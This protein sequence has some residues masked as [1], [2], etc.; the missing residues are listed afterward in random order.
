LSYR[1]TSSAAP[2]LLLAGALLAFGAPVRAKVGTA[3]GDT[4][5]DFTLKD[6]SGAT[7]TLAQYKGSV[8][9]LYFAMWCSTCRANAFELQREIHLPLKEKKV[10]VF[11]VDYLSNPNVDLLSVARDLGLEY[12]VLL[13]D[14]TLADLYG[15][16]M[17]TTLVIDQS[18]IIRCRD[19]YDLEKVKALVWTLAGAKAAPKATPTRL[20]RTAKA[21]TCPLPNR[22]RIQETQAL[23]GTSP[24]EF[25]G[26]AVPHRPVDMNRDGI[27]DVVVASPSAAG[28][29][30]GVFIR[31]GKE[32]GYPDAPDITL[33]GDAA[34]EKL[35][36]SLLVRDMNGDGAPDLIA[37]SSMTQESSG[38]VS[39]FL[40]SEK[41]LPSKPAWTA[42]GSEKG[43]WFGGALAAGDLDGDGHPDLAVAASTDHHRGSVSIYY[44][45]STGPGEKPGTV[46]RGE[47]END[48]FGSSLAVGDLNA[49]GIDDLVIGAT[50]VN[51]PGTDRG[52]IYVFFGKKGGMGAAPSAAGADLMILG[53]HDLDEFGGSVLCAGDLDADGH[54]DLAA[55][56][57][58]SS[59][60]ARR[61]GAVYLFYGPFAR[62][63]AKSEAMAA[64]DAGTILA[65]GEAE[66]LYGVSLSALGDVNQDGLDDLGVGAMNAVQSP[67]RAGAAFIY[68][69][70]KDRKSLKHETLFGS[71]E[72]GRFGRDI[73]PM[74]GSR[75]L[76]TETGNSERAAKAGAVHL[77]AHPSAPSPAPSRSTSQEETDCQ[78]CGMTLSRYR[79][80]RYEVTTKDGSKLVT[81]GVQCGLILQL[82]LGERFASAQ[83]T[84]FITNRSRD[85]TLMHYV[86]ASDAVP[87]MWPSFIAFS[88]LESAQRFQKGFGGEVLSH[89]EALTKAQEIR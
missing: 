60:K 37:G 72:D 67:P 39:L 85:A 89:P 66:S 31:Y 53:E 83:A 61:G 40:S 33:V 3:V 71:R 18:G 30:G 15:S 26:F 48:R 46:L 2:S 52:A 6:L 16:K 14:H 38:K 24:R 54:R 80:T 23:F 43:D 75:F 17:A 42:R 22:P 70:N 74:G 35:G 10:K 65:D 5:P 34:G 11:A 77:F 29:R 7:H 76:V 45:G 4:A 84:D 27:P 8:V 58:G 69:G 57:L 86:Y 68:Y 12:P 25:F 78:V 47:A 56:G 49:D 21:E 82:R 36:A 55:S 20:A 88:S 81:C 19:F 59:R 32:S 87:D 1:R 44:G 50:G 73:A 51:G 13:D 28:G 62:R 64:A 41:G 63:A 79:H 9:V